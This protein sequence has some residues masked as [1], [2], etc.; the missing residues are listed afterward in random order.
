[1]KRLRPCSLIALVA[2]AI[3]LAST[4]VLAQN[5]TITGVRLVI[6]K[7]SAPTVPVNTV[8]VTSFVCGGDHSAA[9]ASTVNPGVL[10]WD[11]PTTAGKACKADIAAIVNA[12]PVDQFVG[13]A[14]F[15]YSD[16][17][18]GP[19]SVASNPFTRFI[20]ATL[21]GLRFVR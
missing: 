17:S 15:V 18:T 9:N 14:A 11:D 10:E 20:Y 21:T 8:N 7:S 1:M 6:F 13:T 5:P 12:L 19:A 16:G 2:L 3:W 4:P